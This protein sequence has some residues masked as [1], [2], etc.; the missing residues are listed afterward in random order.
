MSK[1]YFTMAS[2]LFQPLRRTMSQGRTFDHLADKL[3]EMQSKAEKLRTD[4]L[5][6]EAE[7]AKLRSLLSRLSSSEEV[8]RCYDVDREEIEARVAAI[9][10][11]LDSVRL[12]VETPRDDAQAAAWQHLQEQMS[13]MRQRIEAAEAAGERPP[14]EELVGWVGAA[15]K[16]ESFRGPVDSRVQG[17]LLGCALGDQKVAATQ[18]ADLMSAAQQ[19]DARV[20]RLSAEEK[21]RRKAAAAAAA[22]SASARQAAEASSGGGGEH[23]AE[24]GASEEEED[25]SEAEGG[26]SAGEESAGEIDE[27]VMQPAR[28]A[29][30]YGGA[31]AA[32]AA[33]AAT[34]GMDAARRTAGPDPWFASVRQPAST[35]ASAARMAAAA[36]PVVP[37]ASPA[38]PASLSR[39]PGSRGAATPAASSTSASGGG[40]SYHVEEHR[41]DRHA[42][43]TSGKG[44]DKRRG[45]AS[46]RRDSG[47]ASGAAAAHGFASPAATGA[48]R[49]VS[50]VGSSRRP[51]H[52]AAVPAGGHVDEYGHEHV[53]EEEEEEEE[54][55]AAGVRFSSSAGAFL[56]LEEGEEGTFFA[57]F[58][59]SPLPSSSCALSSP[60]AGGSFRFLCSSSLRSVPSVVDEE[61][62]GAGS[63]GTSPFRW[64][65]GKEALLSRQAKGVIWN[66]CSRW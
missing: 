56:G 44:K 36:P 58:A 62:A 7:Q 57:F 41:D 39:G 26:S 16:S 38:P 23:V 1:L 34:P 11:V 47:G 65:G 20:A 14:V 48:A 12:F 27:H 35:S 15:S 8:A 2:S 31:P 53:A 49:G 28:A 66:H 17:W 54:E 9:Q 37:A 63:D 52:A 59:F 40:R 42:T 19:A 24:D 45:S 33:S 51:P 55:A 6:L 21:A 61:V 5:E 29:P 43:T 30:T 50:S 46:G 25:R 18:I 4:V 32:K 64:P 22:A 3:D 60:L 10:R 13:R